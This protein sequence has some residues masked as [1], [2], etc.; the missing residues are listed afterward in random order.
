ME[1]NELQHQDFI[2]TWK[3]NARSSKVSLWL[4]YLQGVDKLA[5]GKDTYRFSYNG[6]AV[7]CPLN[8]LEFIM[9][10][11]ASGHLSIEFLDRLSAYKIPFFIHRRN[12]VSPYVFYP[13][14]LKS[15]KDIL[16]PQILAREN[17]IKRVYIART[18]IKE[19]VKRF[20]ARIVIPV[21]KVGLL[22]KARTIE[23]I[24]AIEAQ[25]TKRYWSKF[26]D[27][28]GLKASRREDNN[29]VNEA[30]D[31]GS[32]FLFGIILRWVLFHKLSPTHGFLH[33][34]TSYPALCYD[35]M[36]PFRYLVEDSVAHAYSLGETNSKAL[37]Q[38]TFSGIKAR[39]D[40]T[41]Y[42]PS[43]RQ[44]VAR[45]NLLHG[46]VLALRSYLVSE[47]TRFVVPV[48]G[49]KKGGRPPKVAFRLPGGK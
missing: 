15:D 29:P 12:I 37:T 42:V 45:K 9:V 40:E 13:T 39:L 27:E 8:R 4:P 41:V 1:I 38:A 20:S 14:S 18:L 30:L 46:I 31:A 25:I 43:T 5:K 35:L 47:T 26:Y 3:S 22:N 33:E 21:S 10:Y 32:Y 28:L 34:P 16:T 36:E 23:G 49:Q 7:D 24:R 19:R 6:G 48:E 44:R 11:G 17:K 2:W